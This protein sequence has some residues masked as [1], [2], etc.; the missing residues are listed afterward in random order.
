VDDPCNC[1]QGGNFPL[2]TFH[3]KDGRVLDY[4]RQ[5]CP[6]HGIRVDDDGVISWT[7]RRLADAPAS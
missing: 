3:D 7:W 6:V 2:V 4:I 5:D 1:Q